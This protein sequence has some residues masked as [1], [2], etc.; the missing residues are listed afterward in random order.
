MAKKSLNIIKSW[1]KTGLFPTQTQFWDVWDS[2]F[3]KDDQLPAAQVEGLQRLLDQKI[4]KKNLPEGDIGIEDVNNLRSELND[5][6]NKV[7]GKGLSTQNYTTEEKNKLAG[8]EENA[9][10]YQHPA[11]HPVTIINETPEQQFVAAADKTSWYDALTKVNAILNNATADGDTLRELFDLIHALKGNVPEAGNSLEKVYNLITG[12][13]NADREYSDIATRDA[14]K[15]NLDNGES[16]IVNDATADSTVVN[17]WAIYR[18]NQGTQT[19]LKLAERESIDVD[20]SQYMKFTDLVTQYLD[21]PN[22]PAATSLVKA[23]KDVV[24]GLPHDESDLDH[25]KF[26]GFYKHEHLSPG[27]NLFSDGYS[28][29]ALQGYASGFMNFGAMPLTKLNFKVL[30]NVNSNSAISDYVRWELLNEDGTKRGSSQEFVFIPADGGAEKSIDIG[31]S[32]GYKLDYGDKY[33]VLRL[34]VSPSYPNGVIVGYGTD[35]SNFAANLEIFSRGNLPDGYKKKDGEY[36][37]ILGVA[38]LPDS[39]N[40]KPEDVQIWNFTSIQQATSFGYDLDWYGVEWDPSTSLPDCR[41]IGNL[42]Y[43][44]TRPIQSKIKR[45]LLWDNGTVHYYLDADDSTKKADGT[46]SVLDGSHGQVMVEVPEFYYNHELDGTRHRYKISDR[47]I[48]GYKKIKKFYISA[49]E[50]TLQRSTNKLCSLI[51][52]DPDYRGGNNTSSWDGTG[53]TLCGK[54]ATDKTRS[55]FRIAASNRSTKWHQQTVYE[56]YMLSM[57][58]V[59]EYATFNSQLGVNYSLDANGFRQGGLG[60]GATTAVSAEWSAYNSYNPVIPAGTMNFLGNKSGQILVNVADFGGAGIERT[61]HSNSYRGIENPF[62]HIW[63]FIDG[64]N[65]NEFVAYATDDLASLADD[66]INGYEMIGLMPNTNGY[67]KDVQNHLLPLPK[68]VEVD[69]HSRLCDYYQA[70]GWRVARVGGILSNGSNAGLFA[71]SVSY[72]LAGRSANIGA[73]LCFRAE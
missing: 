11:T 62:A 66:S 36:I 38:Y 49:Y 28:L 22:K 8:V 47:P 5:R 42:E 46:P 35:Q 73:R 10:N 45:C 61:F 43:H 31:R 51:N 26:E 13:T 37:I 9:N 25:D 64:L 6:V 68:T 19:F 29:N 63:K 54:P 72:S 16:I 56:Y 12:I 65:V 55:E 50:A 33:A 60:K 67:Q 14:D 59:I 20:L 1:F 2:F 4:D 7:A 40:T 39:Q 18:Y 15:A 32:D 34:I 71:L 52:T 44:R 21:E 58:F 41:R 17:G 48:A 24:D 69:A 70:S 30:V 3:H 53:K 23:L 27:R 57:L